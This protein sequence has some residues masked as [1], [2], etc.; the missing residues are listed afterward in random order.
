MITQEKKPS[1]ATLMTISAE[2]ASEKVQEI[3]H[4]I[5][6]TLGIDFVPNMY[7]AMAS[8][9]LYLEITWRK[10][11]ALMSRQGKLER[12]TKDIIAYVVSVMNGSDYC[13]GVYTETLR[14]AGL[15]D[16]AILEILAII[17]LY[18]GL[19]RLNIGLQTQADEKPWHGCGAKKQEK[20][21]CTSQNG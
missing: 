5:K 20:T 1:P 8:N 19:N 11:Q 9:P 16:E 3:Y 7:Q 14:H 17:D 15:D 21:E 12:M 13:I 2:E 18:S 10:I 4:E 6:E